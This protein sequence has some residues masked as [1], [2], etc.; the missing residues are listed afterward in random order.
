MEKRSNTFNID[1][2]LNSPFLTSDRLNL[3]V[4]GLRRTFAGREAEVALSDF[5]KGGWNLGPQSV[6]RKS[7]KFGFGE[8][9]SWTQLR[10]GKSYELS[11]HLGNVAVVVGDRRLAVD[12]NTDLAVDF[13]EA[14]VLS[15]R[16][17]YPFGMVMPE[18]SFSTQAYR[19]GFNGKGFDS[20]WKG[21]G[22]SYDYGFRVYDARLGR[23]LSVDPLSHDYSGISTFAFVLNTPIQAI[24]PDGRL[25]IFIGGYRPG[26]GRNDQIQENPEAWPL[27]AKISPEMRDYWRTEENRFGQKADMARMFMDGIGDHRARYTSGGSAPRSDATTRHVEGRVKANRFNEMVKQGLIE[28]QDGE[29]IKIVAHSHGGSHAAGFAERLLEFKDENGQPLYNVEIVYY[30]TPHQPT[31]IKHPKGIPGKQYSHP[32]D[33]ISSEDVILLPTGGSDFGEIPGNLE[34]VMEDIMGG[35]GQPPCG[36]FTGNRCGHNVTDNTF[37]GDIPRGD[38]GA[39]EFRK[40]HPSSFEKQLKQ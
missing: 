27:P 2:T 34:R 20:E 37:I 10:G 33:A 13:F 6:E 40:D 23:F 11:D 21:E 7:I 5:E 31:D 25:V 26:I 28:L 1:L 15:A 4:N 24:D 19:Y 30:I 14:E 29:S 36:G 16:D 12:S 3:I 38:E 35:P 39:I 22:N 17:F 8:A 32:G 9:Y 18:R